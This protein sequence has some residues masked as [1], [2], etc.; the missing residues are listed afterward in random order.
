MSDT[1]TSYRTEIRSVLVTKYASFVYLLGTLLSIFSV[2]Q[3]MN[4]WL[5]NGVERL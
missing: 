5:M 3:C 2:K 4:W 1:E